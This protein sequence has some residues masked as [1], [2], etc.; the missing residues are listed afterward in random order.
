MSNKKKYTTIGIVIEAVAGIILTIIFLMVSSKF[1]KIL[2]GNDTF[3]N[4][5]LPVPL[6]FIDSVTIPA[7]LVPWVVLIILCGLLICLGNIYIDIKQYIKN[8]KSEN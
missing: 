7:K 2:L 6:P 5:K 1:I 4:W 8:K 3:V